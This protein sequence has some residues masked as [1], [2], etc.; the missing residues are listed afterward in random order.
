MRF[1]E[2]ALERKPEWAEANWDLFERWLAAGYTAEVASQDAWL[3][4]RLLK[5]VMSGGQV[6]NG[7]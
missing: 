5:Y 6:V 4:E 1:A 2:R 3:V 7:N